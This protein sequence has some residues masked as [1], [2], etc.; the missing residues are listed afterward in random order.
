[1]TSA[2]SAPSA[3]PAPTAVSF[4]DDDVITVPGQVYA[5]VS[6][7][8]PTSTQKS[9][10]CAIKIR[11]VF[12]TL[13][14]AEAHVQKLMRFDNS[15]DIFVVDLYKWLVVPPDPN[16]VEDQRYSDQFLEELMKGYKESQLA[17]KQHFEERK[18]E[19]MEK[20]LDATLTPQERLPPPP[21]VFGAPDPHPSTASTSTAP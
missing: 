15:F 6:V 19:V 9:D 7:V 16:A 10:R 20:G 21:D 13:P 12:G 11:G 5:L 4:L 1:M 14:E 17:A 2:P 3:P 18:R 8:S